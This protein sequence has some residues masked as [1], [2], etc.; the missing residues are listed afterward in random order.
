MWLNHKSVLHDIAEEFVCKTKTLK[1]FFFLIS[2]LEYNIQIHTYIPTLKYIVTLL[3]IFFIIAKYFHLCISFI[4][5]KFNE[6]E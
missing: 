1:I 2:I 3:K 5:E 6:L 4:Y